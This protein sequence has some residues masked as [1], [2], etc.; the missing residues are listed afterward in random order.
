MNELKLIKV[1]VCQ[2][3]AATNFIKNNC[4]KMPP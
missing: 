1:D 3:T 2:S 4:L